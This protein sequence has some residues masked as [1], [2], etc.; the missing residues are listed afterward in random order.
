MPL[1]G[2]FF[3]L[4]G[5]LLCYGNV[6]AAWTD[7][8]NAFHEG[9]IPHG[10]RMSP[11]G[12]SIQCD[13][14]FTKPEPQRRNSAFTIYESRID[15]LCHELGLEVP[16]G[17]ISR[18]ADLAAAAWR[19]H[20]HLDPDCHAVMAELRTRYKLALISNFDHPPYVERLLANLGLTDYFKAVIISGAVG[21]KK[22]DPGIFRIAL[23]RTELDSHQAVHVGDTDDDMLGASAAG[24]QPILIARDLRPAQAA[25]LDFRAGTESSN[26]SEHGS[27]G[28]PQVLTI[29]SLSEL[30]TLLPI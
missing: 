27:G 8:L 15:A 20:L 14:F 24:I 5:T 21:V 7:W 23:E 29:R 11:A 13:G 4:Y 6:Q 3:D 22:P 9:L 10:L 12:F 1:R 18:I 28:S 2:V 25:A 16:P 26:A 19:R 30:L 17:D